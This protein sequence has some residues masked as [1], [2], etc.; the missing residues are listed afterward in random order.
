MYNL[1]GSALQAIFFFFLQKADVIL[2][3]RLYILSRFTK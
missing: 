1:M 3:P 2:A